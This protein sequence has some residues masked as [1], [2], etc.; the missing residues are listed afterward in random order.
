[1][2]NMS[3]RNLLGPQ[4]LEAEEAT[5]PAKHLITAV[6]PRHDLVS[7]GFEPLPR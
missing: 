2:R 5:G 7:I 1:M 3:S 6:V 4:P